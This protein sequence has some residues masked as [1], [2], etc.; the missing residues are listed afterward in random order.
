V[1]ETQV[2]QDVAE[3]LIEEEALRERVAELGAEISAD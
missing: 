2:D 3:I 1:T